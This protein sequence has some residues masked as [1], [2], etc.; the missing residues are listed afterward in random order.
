[1]SA[2][3]GLNLQESL[4]SRECSRESRRSM[5]RLVQFLVMKNL[6]SFFTALSRSAQVVFFIDCR[7]P[8]RMK[9]VLVFFLA[10]KIVNKRYREIP[11]SLIK[12]RKVW[13]QRE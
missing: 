4:M 10:A 7:G 8:V 2:Q 12:L 5:F 3:A 13:A 11:A 6:G 9:G 1:M